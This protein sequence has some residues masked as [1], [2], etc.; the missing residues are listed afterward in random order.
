MFFLGTAPRA[1]FLGYISRSDH[2]EATQFAGLLQCT[3]PAFA[4]LH[5]EDNLQFGELQFVLL[6]PVFLLENDL[7]NEHPWLVDYIT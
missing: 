2:L 1:S 7:L 6:F 3:L 5:P 4:Y